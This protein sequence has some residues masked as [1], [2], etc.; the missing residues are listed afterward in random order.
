[1]SRLETY[2]RHGGYG[3]SMSSLY[4]YW[5]FKEHLFYICISA[6]TSLGEHVN[7]WELCA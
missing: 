4:P 5:L 2:I 7:T 3:V 6:A 1:M